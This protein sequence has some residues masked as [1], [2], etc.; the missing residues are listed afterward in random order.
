MV[1]KMQRQLVR[2]TLRHPD[3]MYGWKNVVDLKLTDETP[4]YETNGKA[5]MDFLK[6]TWIKTVSVTGCKKI[7]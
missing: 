7:I 1:W 6:S 4:Q 5:L 2:T 3:F